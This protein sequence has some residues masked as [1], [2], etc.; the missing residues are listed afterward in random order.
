MYTGSDLIFI[1]ALSFMVGGIILL[2]IKQR[3]INKIIAD[4]DGII[5]DYEKSCKKYTN[6][7]ENMKNPFN[8]EKK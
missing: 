1:G 6:I 7:I 2:L 5:I 3:E 4:Y 8:E